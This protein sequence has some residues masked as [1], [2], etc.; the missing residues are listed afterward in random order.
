MDRADEEN[1]EE[2]SQ[3]SERVDCS[4]MDEFAFNIVLEQMILRKR[5]R[6]SGPEKDSCP[7]VY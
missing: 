3:L 4:D 6:R 5:R 1:P 2:K 7:T